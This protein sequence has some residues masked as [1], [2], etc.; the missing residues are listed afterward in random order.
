VIL[1]F[2]IGGELGGVI[3]ALVALP[4]AAMY[5]TIR[6]NLAGGSARAGGR[7]RPPPDRAEEH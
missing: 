1:A 7:G 6:K 3:G 2:A 5:P 4:I